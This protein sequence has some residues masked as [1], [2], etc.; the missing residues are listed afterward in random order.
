LFFSLFQMETKFILVL[1]LIATVTQEG[2]SLHL[3][4]ENKVV[5]AKESATT[6]SIIDAQAPQ[7]L[8][9]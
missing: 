3:R 2:F 1:L 6:L 8:V 5:V 9:S 7:V 4:G